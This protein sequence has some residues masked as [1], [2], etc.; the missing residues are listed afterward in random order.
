MAPVIH[1]GLAVFP[2][3]VQQLA[4]LAANAEMLPPR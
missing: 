4:E 1:P 2:F 3:T